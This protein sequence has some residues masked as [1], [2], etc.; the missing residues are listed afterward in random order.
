MNFINLQIYLISG[1]AGTV[2]FE[3]T[4]FGI[5]LKLIKFFFVCHQNTLLYKKTESIIKTENCLG[6]KL[7]SYGKTTSVIKVLVIY[8]IFVKINFILIFQNSK[9][10]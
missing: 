2:W 10:L 5:P 6:L 9:L 4:C 1:L 7:G 8:K 3:E